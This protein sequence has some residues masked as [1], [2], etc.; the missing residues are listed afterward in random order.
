M[1][2]TP[3]VEIK[4][5]RAK[6][7]DATAIASF[8][9]DATRGRITAD[10]A[11]VQERLGAK[12]FFL[13]QTT[14]IVGLAGVHVENLVAR[15]EDLIVHPPALR[16]VAGKALLDNIEADANN[17]NCEVALLYVHVNASPGAYEFLQSC[18]YQE[19]DMSDWPP[20]WLNSAAEFGGSDRF[21]MSKRL[22]EHL[23][24]R[25]I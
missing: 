22:R 14:R 7:S 24:T 10:R 2:E 11:Q 21:V 15:I 16:P 19:P 20:A 25:P 23:I 3:Q 4:V 5:R 12:G 18:G 6:F 13:A 1:N 8:L 17:L 9:S